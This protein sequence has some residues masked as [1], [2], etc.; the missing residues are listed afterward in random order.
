[1]VAEFP[2]EYAVH[3]MSSL[4]A[5]EDM[6]VSFGTLGKLAHPGGTQVAFADGSVRY[7]SL[8]IAPETLHALVT[9]NGGERV[10]EFQV[11]SIDKF[12]RGIRISVWHNQNRKTKS[13]C[14]LG[15]DIIDLVEVQRLSNRSIWTHGSPLED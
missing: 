15:D 9:V 14:G 13:I 1:M 12:C 6:V 5:D 8:K 7:I 4:D 11:T 10:G 2:D 3:W